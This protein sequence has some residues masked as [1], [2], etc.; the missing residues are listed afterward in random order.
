M[1]NSAPTHPTG[2]AE[3]TRRLPV[4]RIG[5]T[6]G[7]VGILCCVG[8]TV[9]ALIGVVGAGTAFAWATT[10]YDQGAWWFRLGALVVLAGLVW[11]ALRRRDQC[12]LAG[13]RRLR[14]RLVAVAGI[15][16]ATYAVLYA[17]TTW[18]GSVR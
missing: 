17:V 14:W 16:V 3:R 8:P 13:V 10:L 6:G 15:A 18:L 12:S 11:W 1:T 2:T 9:L 4:W 7:L 5:I